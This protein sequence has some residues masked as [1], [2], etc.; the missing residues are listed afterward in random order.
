MKSTLA[1]ENQL[2]HKQQQ[3]TSAQ[4]EKKHKMPM[5]SSKRHSN[6]KESNVALYVFFKIWVRIG[7]GGKLFV[8]VSYSETISFL[9]SMRFQKIGGERRIHKNPIENI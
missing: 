5:T 6:S 8:L 2:K 3:S 7:C 9:K 1:N 4:Y